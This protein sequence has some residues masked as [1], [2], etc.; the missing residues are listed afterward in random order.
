M[1]N[2]GAPEDETRITEAQWTELKE[3]ASRYAERIYSYIGEGKEASRSCQHILGNIVASCRLV[4]RSTQPHQLTPERYRRLSASID[5]I[6]RYM[7]L[8]DDFPGFAE[9][10]LAPGPGYFPEMFDKYGNSADF[11]DAYE[12]ALRGGHARM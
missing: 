12:A 1:S 10:E 2:E 5:L 6:A 8:L 11:I 3:Q 4:L 7:K 9:K